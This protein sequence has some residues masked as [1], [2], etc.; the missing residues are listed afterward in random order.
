MWVHL[1][2]SIC[3]E[4]TY[5]RKLMK[6]N[7]L[8]SLDS[9]GNQNQI[10]FG[11]GGKP[12]QST[13]TAYSQYLESSDKVQTS[14]GKPV[15]RKP[16]RTI[17]RC[18]LK[19]S[20]STLDTKQPGLVC[21]VCSTAHPDYRAYYTHLIDNTCMKYQEDDQISSTRM[22]IYAPKS[23]TSTV[24]QSR[25][26]LLT[27]T[28]DSRRRPT[29]R[30]NTDKYYQE[31]LRA[32][33]KLIISGP[34][35]NPGDGNKP[36]SKKIK[37]LNQAVINNFETSASYPQKIDSSKKCI[38]PKH[39]NQSS[40]S[41]VSNISEKTASE[42]P[43]LFSSY[44]IAKT[45][46][47][48]NTGDSSTNLPADTEAASLN[49]ASCLPVLCP[50]EAARRLPSIEPE[51]NANDEA[52]FT[53]FICHLTGV[54]KHLL[55][56]GRL[57]QLGYPSLSGQEVLGKVLRLTGTP[58]TREDGLCTE[59]CKVDKELEVQRNF[60]LMKSRLIAIEMN[61]EAFLKICTPDQEIW[62]KFGWRD[63]TVLEIITEIA[64]KF[65]RKV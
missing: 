20:D 37:L 9:Q 52:H 26:T 36:V 4:W 29:I 10:N 48:V 55:G 65:V 46:S 16:P 25:S 56:E 19:N 21:H 60:R 45:E 18:I 64:D 33:N 23:D 12:Q 44:D 30:L 53:Y 13:Q 14:N 63:K 41:Q 62:E 27:N 50:C 15:S 54:M 59:A 58:V 17:H 24:S 47:L 40:E 57:T 38:L 5:E 3:T 6:Q 34:S 2:S 49:P 61:T 51:E 7:F 8:K 42:T 1:K 32:D 39:N 22:S 43:L 11:N 35:L 28:A 31:C